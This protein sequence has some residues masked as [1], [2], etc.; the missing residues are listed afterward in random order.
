M[1]ILDSQ[2]SRAPRDISGRARVHPN[3]AAL[4]SH[5]NDGPSRMLSH[6]NGWLRHRAGLA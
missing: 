3:V 4:G 5:R 2:R 1:K 6:G